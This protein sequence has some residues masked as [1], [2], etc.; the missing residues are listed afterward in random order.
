M[1]PDILQDIASRS[2]V[3]G[4]DEVLNRG[5]VPRVGA[6]V[7]LRDGHVAA[8]PAHRP[9]DRLRVVL[10]RGGLSGGPIRRRGISFSRARR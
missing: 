1:T 4:V 6:A 2:A 5:C 10:T 9:A 3:D 7:S 8:P